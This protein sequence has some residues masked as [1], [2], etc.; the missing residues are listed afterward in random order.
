[1]SHEHR[2]NL[3]LV[4]YKERTEY[5]SYNNAFLDA[6]KFPPRNS[7]AS[8]KTMR[9]I[10]RDRYGVGVRSWGTSLEVSKVH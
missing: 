9:K 2:S 6:V 8:L 7:A 1:M 4:S 3:G 5:T 10:A